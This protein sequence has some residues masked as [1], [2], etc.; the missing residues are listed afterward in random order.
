M[1]M[2]IHGTYPHDE[3]GKWETIERGVSLRRVAKLVGAEVT[4]EEVERHDNGDGWSDAVYLWLN[5]GFVLIDSDV[6][7]M[8][9][10]GNLALACAELLGG[11]IRAKGIKKGDRAVYLHDGSYSI[12]E[13]VED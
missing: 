13:R 2:K 3:W 6:N 5:K 12:I 11:S 8:R 10:E 7:G 9:G 1:K 4:D